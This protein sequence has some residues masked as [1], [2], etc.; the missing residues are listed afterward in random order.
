M[1]KQS[2][3]NQFKNTRRHAKLQFPKSRARTGRGAAKPPANRP[4]WGKASPG[5][6]A[7]GEGQK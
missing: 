2:F 4:P 6:K 3:V 1:G 5:E 7:K